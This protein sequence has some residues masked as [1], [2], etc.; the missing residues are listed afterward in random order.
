MDGGMT[1]HINSMISP[2]PSKWFFKVP[3]WRRDPPTF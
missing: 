2:R 1:D 3:E